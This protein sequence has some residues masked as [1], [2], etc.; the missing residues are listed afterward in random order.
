MINNHI[1]YIIRISMCMLIHV[2]FTNNKL[3]N[4]SLNYAYIIQLC[5]H[6][7]NFVIINQWNDSIVWWITFACNKCI[8]P[9]SQSLA[10]GPVTDMVRLKPNPQFVFDCFVCCC[11]FCLPKC[12][13]GSISIDMGICQAQHNNRTRLTLLVVCLISLQNGIPSTFP[14]HGFEQR[15]H[16]Q[17]LSFCAHGLHS[18]P[19]GHRSIHC[20]ETRG[21]EGGGQGP[22]PPGRRMLSESQ[23]QFGQYRGQTFK[24]LLSHD[25][26]Y[27]CGI[28]VEQRASR[29]APSTACRPACLL[30]SLSAW[31][32]PLLVT[33][34]QVKMWTHVQ[35]CVY[36]SISSAARV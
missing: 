26:G 25:V 21:G 10:K 5:I 33:G 32:P 7:G 22:H 11:L 19:Q 17:G 27:A 20:E 28:L 31:H 6:Y 23:L 35:T 14:A 13:R 1:Q 34:A 24:W 2:N 30:D 4:V 3:L 12:S 16:P 36:L 8:K 18:Q 15:A 9:V 29:P